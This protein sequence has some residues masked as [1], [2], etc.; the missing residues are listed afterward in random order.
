MTERELRKNK[1]IDYKSLHC[2]VSEDSFEMDKNSEDISGEDNDMH[3]FSRE[4]VETSIKEAEEQLLN[5][6]LREKQLTVEFEVAS[7]KQKIKDL[8]ASIASLS[9]P[10]QLGQ[11]ETSGKEANGKPAVLP[12]PLAPG[13]SYGQMATGY[14]GYLDTPHHPGDQPSKSQPLGSGEGL[15]STGFQNNPLWNDQLLASVYGPNISEPPVHVQA[16]SNQPGMNRAANGAYGGRLDLNPQVY[17]RKSTSATGKYRRIVDFAPR[18]D[19]YNTDDDE[20]EFGGGLYYRTPEAS[21][22]R[23]DNLTPAQWVA[24]NSN[25][26]WD[27]IDKEGPNIDVQM[28]VGDYMSYTTKI[29]EMATRYTWRSIFRYDDE[30]RFKQFLYGYRWGSDS[31]HLATI[32]LEERQKKQQWSNASGTQKPGSGTPKFGGKTKTGDADSNNKTT[33]AAAVC[34]NFNDGRECR[35]HPCRFKHACSQ[36][37]KPH[38]S[39]HH[40][41]AQ[42]SSKSDP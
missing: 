15:T 30:Y 18:K 40:D 19:G 35:S 32:T 34:Y 36:C 42:G 37:G 26:L 1:R 39:V 11:D 23:L 28:L 14:Q 21:R 20:V 9:K 33:P 12:T 7:K 8:Q 41:V 13:A 2:G 10:T 25:I 5:L 22:L 16:Y 31:A 27:I 3:E 6:D 4:D 17:L 38:A 29:G 24:A